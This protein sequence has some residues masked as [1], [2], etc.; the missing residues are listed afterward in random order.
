MQASC[1]ESDT[2]K[3]SRSPDLSARKNGKEKNDR[4]CS[5]ELK[6]AKIV[7][8]IHQIGNYEKGFQS[9]IK[10]A[11]TPHLQAAK[12]VYPDGNAEFPFLSAKEPFNLW[13]ERECQQASTHLGKLGIPLRN[14]VVNQLY[15]LIGLN[16]KELAESTTFTYPALFSGKARYLERGKKKIISH[17]TPFDVEIHSNRKIYVIFLREKET[18]IERGNFKDLFKVF[19]LGIPERIAYSIAR[20]N[21]HSPQSFRN[22]AYNEEQFLILLQGKPLMAKIFDIFYYSVILEG[23]IFEK[24]ITTLEYYRIGFF[25]LLNNLITNK[26][27]LSDQEKSLFT[28]QLLQAI[29]TLHEQGIIHRDIKPENLMLDLEKMIALIDFGLSCRLSD[30][31]A[32]KNTVGSTTYTAPEVF[33]EKSHK[34]GLTQDMWSVGCVLWILW[35]EHLYPWH[36]EVSPKTQDV[37]KALILMSEFSNDLTPS[38]QSPVYPFWRMLRYNYQSRW[39]VSKALIHFQRLAQR[40]PKKPT[41]RSRDMLANEINILSK[42]CKKKMLIG[43]KLKTSQYLVGM[44]TIDPSSR[45]SMK[46]P[47]SI[48]IPV[49]TH[50]RHQIRAF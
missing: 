37:R 28:C 21:N 44:Q 29:A 5:T 39:S 9:T 34:A 23:Q 13:P 48:L 32:L 18:F 24:Q 15:S 16:Q 27:R 47:Y 19:S 6:T 46:K 42:Q 14:V 45:V 11:C 41:Y 35:F 43:E 3:L 36:R 25:D 20:L 12:S 1:F 33:N 4:S 50:P 2:S 8:F 10:I 40:L 38:Y 22:A 7:Y 30:V 26:L 17:K 49:K 31:E